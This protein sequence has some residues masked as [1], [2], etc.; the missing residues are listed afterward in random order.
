MVV[1]SWTMVPRPILLIYSCAP[2]ERLISSAV[3]RP[4]TCCG[5]PALEHIRTHMLHLVAVECPNDAPHREHLHPR[6]WPR[7]PRRGAHVQRGVLVTRAWHPRPNS[8]SRRI[9]AR[10]PPPWGRGPPT[11]HTNRSCRIR[12]LHSP[13]VCPRS[14]GGGRLAHAERLISVQIDSVSPTVPVNNRVAHLEDV[15]RAVR[16]W[17]RIHLDHR[18]RSFSPLLTGCRRRTARSF[19]LRL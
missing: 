1:S 15:A 2:R 14:T 4:C 19:N 13:R 10:L 18:R 9:F 5:C 17:F 16:R 3:L 7:V 12:T 8:L 11:I 6:P